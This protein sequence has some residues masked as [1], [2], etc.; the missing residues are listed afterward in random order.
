MDKLPMNQN[1]H[2]LESLNSGSLASGYPFLPAQ[3]KSLKSQPFS[4]RRKTGNR[5]VYK[6]RSPPI[7]RKSQKLEFPKNRI[8]SFGDH[9]KLNYQFVRTKMR[10]KGGC[11]KKLFD[12]FTPS[13]RG[14][15]PA[16]APNA[17]KNYQDY[18]KQIAKSMEMVSP[19]TSK[20]K[21]SRSRL[22]S[23]SEGSEF[24]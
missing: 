21:G 11:F 20:S 16:E 6:I 15:K 22:V 2:K 5:A 3:T 7:P 18:A 24:A 8:L 10:P 1:F 13:L 12:G 23:N 19:A 17:R 4:R 14:L 9:R